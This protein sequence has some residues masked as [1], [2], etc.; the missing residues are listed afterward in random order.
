MLLESHWIVYGLL[1]S[2]MASVHLWIGWFET[3]FQRSENRWMGFIGGIAT[4]YVALYLLPKLSNVTVRFIEANPDVSWALQHWAYF[5]LLLGIV[6]HLVFE[7]TSGMGT[8]GESAARWLSILVLA[9]YGFLVGYV[10]VEL[11]RAEIRFHVL[12][13]VIFALHLMGMSHRFRVRFRSA[14][15]G[16]RSMAF[17]SL[18]V[19][20]YVVG[21]ITELPDS[22]ISGPNAFV[23]G[24][25]LVGILP[26]ELPSRKKGQLRYFLVGVGAFVVVSLFRI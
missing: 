3:R 6:V 14:H 13:N 8:A 2:I 25:V 21:V 15:A 17:A 4:G 23:A 24:I 11:P 20:G 19:L 10:A 9:V 18:L 7:R 12:A 1:A 16:W 22:V 5:I 26:E